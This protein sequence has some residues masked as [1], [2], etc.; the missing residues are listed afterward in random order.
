MTVR[1]AAAIPDLGAPCPD[2]SLIRDRDG[3]FPDLFDVV[4]ADAGI[5]TARTNMLL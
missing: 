3:K 4:L 5:Q 2:R 1:A